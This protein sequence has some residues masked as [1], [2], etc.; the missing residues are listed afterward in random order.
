MRYDIVVYQQHA[1]IYY[2]VTALTSYLR[3]KGL[4]STVIIDVLEDDPINTIKKLNPKIIGISCMST[5]HEWLLEA[6]TAIRKAVPGATIIVG[7]IHGILYPRNILDETPVDLVCNSDGEEVLIRVIDELGK[8]SPRFDNIEGLAFRDHNL[9]V[10][11]NERARLFIYSDGIIENQDAYFDRY[12][13]L[14]YTPGEFGFISSRGCPYQCSFCYN[15]EIALA[16]KKKGA[17]LRRKS[18]DNFLAEIKYEVKRHNPVRTHFHDD[19]FTYNKQWLFNFL[20]RYKEEIGLPFYCAT[21]ANVL[22]DEIARNLAEAGCLRVNYGLETGNECMRRQVLNKHITDAQII[23]CGE[24]LRKYN[25]VTVTSNMFCLP[26][27]TPADSRLTVELNHRARTMLAASTVFVP[28][29]DTQLARYAIEK[30]YLKEN[31]SINDIPYDALR[32]GI[33]L[34]MPQKKE[35]YHLRCLLYFFVRWPWTYKVFRPVTR[36]RWLTPIFSFLFNFGDLLCN[37]ALLSLSFIGVVSYF[38]KLAVFRSKR[39]RNILKCLKKISQP[40][41]SPAPDKIR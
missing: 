21:R 14:L 16:F 3:S 36:V 26:G 30:G 12:G 29:P 7:G 34:K 10:R 23:N 13:S 37:K 35:I 2:G 17:Y 6:S 4:T 32:G 39:L 19:L 27:E 25:I 31:Y 24:N 11:I 41:L 20:R 5:Q 8:S 28:F 40:G 38:C 33:A 15:A 9:N 22:D 18:I 1:Q